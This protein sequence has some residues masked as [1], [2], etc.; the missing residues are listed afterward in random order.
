APRRRVR[1]LG[2]SPPR[3]RRSSGGVA[4]RSGTPARWSDRPPGAAGARGTAAAR[5]RGSRRTAGGRASSVH[6]LLR[7]GLP[8]PDARVANPEIPERLAQA[9]ELGVRKL[10]DPVDPDAA[11]DVS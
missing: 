6:L 9:L 8:A 2:R 1:G 3:A 11:Q 5:P 10:V 7:V 4:S